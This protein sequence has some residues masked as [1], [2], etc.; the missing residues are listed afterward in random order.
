MSK[1]GFETVICIVPALIEAGLFWTPAAAQECK[2]PEAQTEFHSP[3]LLRQAVEAFRIATERAREATE[4]QRRTKALD[5]GSYREA[6]ARYREDIAA[7][8]TGVVHA[9]D[10]PCPFATNEIL[11][12]TVLPEQWNRCQA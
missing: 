2:P 10:L 8:R 6:I 9:K 1:G 4:E 5:R 11:A 7:Y 12:L 3:K